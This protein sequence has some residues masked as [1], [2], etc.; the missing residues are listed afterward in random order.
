MR[1]VTILIL[2]T[3]AAAAYVA[4]FAASDRK[5]S[6]DSA[7]ELVSGQNGQELAAGSAG[8]ALGN[9]D[10]GPSGNG[11]QG[12]GGAD[13]AS[14][15]MAGSTGAGSGS[16]P[17]EF[18][19]ELTMRSGRSGTQAGAG[20]QAGSQRA[21]TLAETQAAAEGPSM[22]TRRRVAPS[23]RQPSAE[24]NAERD[25][26]V[27]ER[28]GS[29]PAAADATAGQP[30]EVNVITLPVRTP[31]RERTVELAGIKEEA[32]ALESRADALDAAVAAAAAKGSET[33]LSVQEAAQEA[34]SSSAA[35]STTPASA[36]VQNPTVSPSQGSASTANTANAA[37]ANAAL[38]VRVIDSTG[39][40]VPKVEV[41][42]INAATN[43]AVKML[44]G[45]T[46]GAIVAD[47]LSP[48]RYRLEVEK[49]SVP[50]GVSSPIG[51][52]ECRV[53]AEPAGYGSVCVE[54][55]ANGPTVLADI[56]LPLSS[57]VQGTILGKTGA[58]VEGVL[59]RAI[60]LVP[61][62]EKHRTVAETNDKGF[63]FFAL[64]PGPYK[65]QMLLPGKGRVEE[66]TRTMEVVA[67]P[68]SA[69]LLDAVDFSKKAPERQSS[70]VQPS[71]VQPSPA[72]PAARMGLPTPAPVEPVRVAAKPRLQPQLAAK[73][74]V[75]P[76][77]QPAVKSAAMS[78]VA[79]ASF[80]SNGASGAV[81]L[82]KPASAP[83]SALTVEPVLRVQSSRTQSED[84]DSTAKPGRVELR[85][86]VI[87][88]WGE[89]VPALSVVV[90]SL[91]GRVLEATQTSDN[92]QYILED[93]PVGTVIVKIAGDLVL[94][95]EG[96]YGTTLLKR[97]V[98]MR[99]Q[100]FSGQKR[101]SLKD[102]VVDI[103]R[104]Y[105][106]SGRIK[107]QPKALAEFKAS[108]GRGNKGQPDLTETQLRRAYYRGLRLTQ[109]NRGSQG[110][111]KNPLTAL[112]QAI[113]IQYDGSFVWTC[114]L[115][116]EDILLV[117]EPRSSRKANGYAGPIGIPVTPAG[118]RPAELE[119]AYPPRVKKA[120][121]DSDS[122][123]AE[124][125]AGR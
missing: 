5:P 56:V 30:E 98:P 76:A 21:N 85:G 71:A 13:A 7:T 123:V 38:R 33:V 108:L 121:L 91:E 47:V 53:G 8:S 104:V 101:V 87:S 103:R 68:G 66:L 50:L 59:V 105:R 12:S 63:F 20:S 52:D 35:T 41:A 44:Q 106:L 10:M 32:D 28:F 49:D 42:V 109:K 65:L 111:T 23:V 61:G 70:A 93:L 84:K 116:A 75:K 64:V 34:I 36:S 6:S 96:R 26:L 39:R 73:P 94:N 81:A 80:A 60:S 118:V 112:G 102:V 119:I 110:D 54:L 4:N 107:V 124:I 67:K 55:E 97:P 11:P 95:R 92:G 45:G 57:G 58:P 31:A 74:A 2:F 19:S 114:P 79:D 22:P 77:A 3:L 48:G 82:A 1:L 40:A 51:V 9:G 25:R 43:R 17:S 122:I 29:K 37:P 90:E 86:R 62:Y 88:K 100:T 72:Q 16:L 24:D 113:Q 18:P 27:A 83:R 117:L 125:S 89:S 46:D 99:V 14:S 120:P 15:S 78:R 69:L 115:P